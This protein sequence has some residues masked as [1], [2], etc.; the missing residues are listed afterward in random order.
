MFNIGLW[1]IVIVLLVA[2]LVVGPDDLPKVAR[3][4]GRQ[5]R[6]LKKILR[7]I[8][9]E[10]GW[11]EVEKE[12]KDVQKDVR[13]TIREIDVTA[14]VKVAVR[15][16]EKEVKAIGTDMEKD[17][18][19]LDRDVKSETEQLNAEIRAAAGEAQDAAGREKDGDASA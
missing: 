3:W 6:S 12:I 5:V 11:D 13:A 10:T 9:K 1:E 17:L 15:D 16:V 18:R 7:E 4:L 2:F 14:D 8:K 19:Q